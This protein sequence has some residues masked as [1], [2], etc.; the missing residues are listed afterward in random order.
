MVNSAP[1]EVEE[2]P[3][4]LWELVSPEMDAWLNSWPPE[5][6]TRY[7]G[8]Y[9]AVRQKQIVAADRSLGRLFKKLDG[10]GLTYRVRLLYVEEPDAWVIY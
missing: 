2:I 6:L 4:E 7:G 5:V 8:Q 10:L 1:T 3:A 9:I